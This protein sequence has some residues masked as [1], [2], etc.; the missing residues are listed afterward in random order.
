M[1]MVKSNQTKNIVKSTREAIKLLPTDHSDESLPKASMDALQSLRGVGVAT[2]SLVLSLAT[3]SGNHTPQIP[4]YSDDLYLWLCLKDY[5]DAD[6]TEKPEPTISG[7]G[8]A[9]PVASADAKKLAKHRRPNGELNVKYSITEY[10]H[11][12]NAA[13]TLR[14]RLNS[15]VE[16]GESIS[17]NDIEKVA[18]VLRNI[19]VSGF[20]EGVDSIDILKARA[21][22]R[23]EAEKVI[24]AER[25]ALNSSAEKMASKKRKREEKDKTTKHGGRNKKKKE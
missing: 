17:H 6:P 20:Y 15:E 25:D 10:K 23:E 1:G 5:P 4:F 14:A 11:L 9:A 21:A 8:A 16:D 24:Q 13:G 22:Q 2:A 18:Y 3:G 19:A 12:F 7:A